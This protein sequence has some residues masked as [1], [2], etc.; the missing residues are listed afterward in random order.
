ML[1][2]R[3][4]RP[5]RCTRKRL[6]WPPTPTPCP[7]SFRGRAGHRAAGRAVRPDAQ[8]PWARAPFP[9]QRLRRRGECSCS[10]PPR[11]TL[12][13]HDWTCFSSSA[14]PIGSAPPGNPLL[15]PRSP[16]QLSVSACQWLLEPGRHR[17]APPERLSRFFSS[18]RR[19]LRPG[20]AACL[21]VYPDGAAGG[22]ALEARRLGWAVSQGASPASVDPLL[23]PPM[24]GGGARGRLRRGS[25]RGLSTPDPGEEALPLPRGRRA[26]HHHQRPRAQARNGSPPSRPW[27]GLGMPRWR[28]MSPRP[29]RLSLGAARALPQAGAPLPARLADARGVRWLVVAPGA[30]SGLSLRNRHG[31]RRQVRSAGERG[32]SGGGGEGGGG[33]PEAPQPRA[34][35]PETGAV[36]RGRD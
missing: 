5:A 22:E 17:E 26:R 12:H 14:A 35:E 27:A 30:L 20:A 31:T 36:H 28:A 24:A 8:R 6:N 10:R 13:S 18:L 4:P 33:A 32:E 16:P 3:L 7:G 23:R 15:P 2:R 25:C 11:L 29:A 21:Q 34:A 19:C 1:V 9:R